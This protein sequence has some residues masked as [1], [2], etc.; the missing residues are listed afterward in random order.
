MNPLIAVVA[1]MVIVLVALAVAALI[2]FRL[3]R[4]R[5]LPVAMR[6]LANVGDGHGWRHGVLV[7]SNDCAEMYK[8]RSLRPS[9]D[10]IID[11]RSA[12]VTSRRDP[13]WVEAGFFDPGTHVIGIADEGGEAWEF[14]VDSGGDTALVAWIESSPSARQTRRLPS[15]M[16]RRYRE[17]RRRG[18]N[19]A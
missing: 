12:S 14:A 9:A 19:Q 1:L 15:D 8:L 13:T 6:P 2:R 17:F 11:R 3:V 10:L 7:F 5:G 4:S 16:D 18:M